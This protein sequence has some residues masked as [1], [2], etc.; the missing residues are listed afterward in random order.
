MGQIMTRTGLDFLGRPITK[1]GT[2]PKT[3]RS[4]TFFWTFINLALFSA[5]NVKWSQGME[6]TPADI[7]ALAFVNV[8]YLFF[9]VYLTF[10][11]RGSLREKYFI[12]ESHCFDF[13]DCFCAIFCLPCSLCQMARHTADY[14][15][16]QG[17][18]CNDTG[19]PE[20]VD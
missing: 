16:N 11:T 2:N 18:C 17:V 19:I 1:R 13:E 6:L 9:I 14:N 3:L 10:A 7:C 8:T 20:T 15:E 12:R 4:L 5:Y